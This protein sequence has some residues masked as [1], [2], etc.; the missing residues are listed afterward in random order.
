MKLNILLYRFKKAEKRKKVSFH[1]L[2]FQS[3]KRELEAVQKRR[4]GKKE[5]AFLKV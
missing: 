4:R 5:T 1:A 2:F 3:K